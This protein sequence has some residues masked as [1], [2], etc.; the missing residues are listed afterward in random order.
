MNNGIELDDEFELNGVRLM[1]D[2]EY[3][4]ADFK[5]NRASEEFKALAKEGEKLEPKVESARKK[6]EGSAKKVTNKRSIWLSYGKDKSKLVKEQKEYEG[7]LKRNKKNQDIVDGYI[8]ESNEQV[9]LAVEDFK[10][11]DE[12]FNDLDRQLSVNARDTELAGRGARIIKDHQ[13]NANASGKNWL[14]MDVKDAWK[15]MKANI[16]KQPGNKDDN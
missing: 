6:R 14:Q 12:A 3:G 13:D 16:E 4:Y 11:D 1:E 5:P 10:V 15:K 7:K 9:K 2:Q 8:N